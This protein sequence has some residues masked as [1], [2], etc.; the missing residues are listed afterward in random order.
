[1]VIKIFM[2]KNKKLFKN[3]INFFEA[4]FS[5]VEIVIAS[6]IIT[7]SLVCIVQLAGQSIVFSRQAVNVYTSASLLEEGAESVR[8]IRDS[9]W[10][11]ISAFLNST[12]YYPVFATSTNSWSLTTT[13]STVG[14]FTRIVTFSPVYRDTNYNIST[15]GTLATS[16]RFVTVTVSWKESVGMI[17]KTLSFYLSDIF[18]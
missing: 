13:T 16:V 10:G 4:G 6:A 14:N 3:K 17:T 9:G 15:T 12:N 11:N 2:I 18:S 8:T 7:I 5:L 1:V